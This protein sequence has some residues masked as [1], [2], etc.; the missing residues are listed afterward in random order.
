MDIPT[1]PNYP[2]EKQN[3]L[4]QI[5]L[6]Y[7]SEEFFEILKNPFAIPSILTGAMT[8]RIVASKTIFS[9]SQKV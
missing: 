7:F 2:E 8:I 9:F 5:L 3:Y 6:T 1:K 4:S